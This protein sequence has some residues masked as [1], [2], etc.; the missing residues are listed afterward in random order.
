MC[1]CVCVCVGMSVCARVCVNLWARVRACVRAYHLSLC[2][3]DEPDWKRQLYSTSR[4]RKYRPTVSFYGQFIPIS[5]M[6]I[7]QCIA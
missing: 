6:L 4:R 3:E 5:S 2:H 7:G 1:V